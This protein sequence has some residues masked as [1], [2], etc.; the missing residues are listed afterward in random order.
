MAALILRRILAGVP[1]MLAV[2]TVAFALMHIAPG[3]PFDQDRQPP[4]GVLEQLERQYQLDLP[5]Y[6]QYLNY[7]SSLLRGDLGPSYR[8]PGY[9]VD[10]LIAQGLPASLELGLYALLIAL[11]LGTATGLLAA[12]NHNRLL[13]Y[14]PM[15]LSLAGICIPTFLLGPLLVLV[16]GIYLQWLPVSGWGQLPGDKILPSVTL[17]AAY[18]AYLARLSRGGMLEVMNQDFIR[19]ARAKGIGEA[20]IVV[21]H[22]LRIALLPALAFLGPACAGLLSGSFVVETI[23]QVPGLG[24]AYVQ[25]AFNRDYTMILGTTILFSA[26]IVGFNLLSDLLRLAMDPVLREE[27]A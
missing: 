22:A 24:R 9:S 3:G 15:S 18:T 7:L 21:V 11:L 27:N 26:L 14:L 12:L 1:V 23:F 20:R 6:R 2:I 25:S 10:E 16:F 5:W 19:T 4:T 13:D 8:H 17:G